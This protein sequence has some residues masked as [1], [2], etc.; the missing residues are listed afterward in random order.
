MAELIVLDVVSEPGGV[1]NEDMFGALPKAAWVLDGA[2]GLGERRLF[3]TTSDAQ[4]YVQV[5]DRAFARLLKRPGPTL[6]EAVRGAVQAARDELGPALCEQ[7]REAWELPS[8]SAV[9]VGVASQGL[10]FATLGDCKVV[11][12]GI[13]GT[14]VASQD[15]RLEQLDR[16]VIAEIPGLHARGI[17]GFEPVFAALRAKV[18]ANRARMNTPDGYWALSLSES[19][20][21]H[22]DQGVIELN[23][24]GHALLVSDGFFRLVDTFRLLTPQELLDA[25]VEGGLAALYTQ[26]RAVEA[27]DPLCTRYPRLKPADDATAVL[28]RFERGWR[29]LRQQHRWHSAG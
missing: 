21:E 26:L 2:T 12:E 9:V 6:A 18:R 16:E 22:M 7:A 17:V 14:V 25:A 4:V 11:A 20:A 28:L 13:G 19:A 15:T 23:G 1:H 27:A 24:P 8:A 29:S 3:A 5:I 10:A